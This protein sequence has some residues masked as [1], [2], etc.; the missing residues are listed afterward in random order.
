MS[1]LDLLSAVMR[2]L[3]G[4]TLS[5]LLGAAAI[6]PAHAAPRAVEVFDRPAWPALQ[7]G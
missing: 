6:M 3:A 1:C 4:R 5:V 2:Q 7:A